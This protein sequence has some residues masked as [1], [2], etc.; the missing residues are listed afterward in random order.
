VCPSVRPSIL[1]S[2]RPSVCLFVHP[3]VQWPVR[4]PPG[5]ERTDEVEEE[6]QL[7]GDML[8]TDTRLTG[9][10]SIVHK[11][12]FVLEHVVRKYN[13]SFIMK[14]DDD[15]YVNMRG[16]IQELKAQCRRAFGP[17]SSAY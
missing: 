11:T 5:T 12:Y 16:L 17:H 7:H 1:L 15:T 6:V 9:Y 8:F 14:A 10:R 13:A 2:V 4:L 3:S